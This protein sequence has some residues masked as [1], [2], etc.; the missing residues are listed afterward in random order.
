MVSTLCISPDVNFLNGSRSI[1]YDADRWES[2]EEFMPERYMNYPL[3]AA[4]YSTAADPNTR[5]HFSYGAGRR[6]CPGIHLAEKSLFL[7]IARVLCAF[8]LSKKTNEEGSVVEPESGMVPGWM[9]IPLPFECVIQCRSCE[10]AKMIEDAWMDAKKGLKPDG[11]I[12][13]GQPSGK[14]KWSL[15]P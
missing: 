1:N 4:A 7:N 5:D 14:R 3:S 12:P 11:D 6:I 10:K 13:D 8:D 2:P 15:Q 9:T